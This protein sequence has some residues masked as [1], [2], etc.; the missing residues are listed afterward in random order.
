MAGAAEITIVLLETQDLMRQA[1]LRLLSA[2]G[3][4]VVGEARTGEE[5][6]RLVFDRRPDVVLVDL[7][8]RGISGV[9]IVRRL[10][11]LDPPSRVLVFTS[12]GD[13]EARDAEARDA[14]A[15]VQAILAGACG[16]VVKDVPPEE[17]VRAVR[18][19]AG[20]DSVICSQVTGALLDR[21]RAREIPVTARGEKAAAAI[22]AALTRRELEI[23]ARLASGRS[24]Q[25]IG[26]ELSLSENTIRNHLASILAKLHLDNRIQAAVQAVR[27]G[28]S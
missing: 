4:E 15:V 23:F 22:R 19:V 12:F 17:I 25:E 27:T 10:S 11:A 6:I 20:G 24:N 13:A 3:V 28:I 2:A 21:I 18:A 5:G 16:Y 9:E 1:L 26:C 8:V 7:A 14:E